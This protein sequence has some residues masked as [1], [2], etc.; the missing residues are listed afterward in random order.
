M[1]GGALGCSRELASGQIML[2]AGGD[3]V[4]LAGFEDSIARVGVG[5]DLVR[6]PKPGR[7]CGERGKPELTN[8]SGAT[9][10]V[11]K[12]EVHGPRRHKTFLD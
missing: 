4:G 6:V 9:S 5:L 2:L 12:S 8:V 1:I 7:S 3:G 11:G 10:M